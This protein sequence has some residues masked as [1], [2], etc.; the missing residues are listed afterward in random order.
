MSLLQ[1][2]TNIST[3][4]IWL[5]HESIETTHKY[6]AADIKLKENALKKLHEPKSSHAN[7]RYHASNDI[8]QFL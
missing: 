7:S 5:G 4:A 6:M 1:S 8:L 3:I 2:G